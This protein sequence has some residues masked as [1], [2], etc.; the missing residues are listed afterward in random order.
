LLPSDIGRIDVMLDTNP[1][2]HGFAHDT[3]GMA[4]WDLAR[5]IFRATTIDK[6]ASIRRITEDVIDRRR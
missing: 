3:R 1:L 6:G 5:G 2:C 4:S